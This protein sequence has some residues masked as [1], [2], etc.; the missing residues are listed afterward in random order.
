M[1]I[2][3][4]GRK[5]CSVRNNYQL[6]TFGLFAYLGLFFIFFTLPIFV[7]AADQEIKKIEF[8]NIKFRGDTE[9]EDI[10]QSEEDEEFEPRIVKL[11]KILLT[12]YYK[13]NGFLDIFVDD[14]IIVHPRTR[15][16]TIQY[17]IFEGQRYYHSGTLF[18]G[19]QDITSEQLQAA[20]KNLRPGMPFDES[21]VTEAARGAEDIYYNNG[22]PFVQINVNYVYSDSL[23]SVLL[24]IIENQTVYIKDIR[25][26]GQEK[27]DVRLIRRELKIKKGEQYNRKAMDES[28][29]NLYATNLFRYVRFELDPVASEPTQAVLNV[30]VQEKDPRWL[31]V[32]F[33]L[34]HEQEMSYGN[35]LEF[36]LQVGHRNLFSS[37]RSLS[38]YLTPSIIYDF[39]RNRLHNSD[40]RI[41][42]LFGEPWLFNTRT[43]GTLQLSYEQYRW[44]NSGWFDLWRAA[45]DVRRKPSKS[46]EFSAAVAAKFIDRLTETDID[47]AIALTID[48]NKSEVYSFTLYGKKDTRENLFNPSDDSY[49][50]L[51]LTF[52][53][54][55]G[56]N[57]SGVYEVNRYFTLVGSWQ[58]YQP[59][60]PKI[61]KFKR[62]NLTF[63]TRLKAGAIL[64]PG[65]NGLIPINDRFYAGGGTTVR[66][67]QEQ[68][69]GP[70]L[71]K[72]SDGKITKAAGGKLLALTNAELRIPLFWLL[73]METFLDGG[74]V[75]GEIEDFNPLDYKFSFGAG[76]ALLTPLGPIRVDYGYKLI[77]SSVDATNYAWHFG[78]YFAF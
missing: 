66:G 76:L 75:W 29:Q 18:K 41:G 8:Q 63:A 78:L 34:A 54:T 73:M 56:K 13:K 77:P 59:F 74:S 22:K 26:S 19:N 9:L 4:G 11:D 70:A 21:L 57:E 25:Y 69:L 12:N 27:V 17:R 65:K 5:C 2:E 24:N 43:P 32:R 60:R 14:S 6:R 55:R 28:Q 16:V 67:Y 31:G 50:D 53:Y 30:L 51:S 10:I 49:T 33:G 48:V 44:L 36:T 45:F 38:L 47:S 3:I 64:E 20:F 40:N 46:V 71:V 37:G 15:E 1:T 61:L 62:M 58:R 35:K 42:M 23:I 7:Q 72:N 68:L 52:S 39:S